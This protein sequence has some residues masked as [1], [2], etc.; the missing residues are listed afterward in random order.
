MR[1]FGILMSVVLCLPLAL[2]AQNG[3][4]MPAGSENADTCDSIWRIFLSAQR[5]QWF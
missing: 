5:Q 1:K 3:G 2:A 4:A